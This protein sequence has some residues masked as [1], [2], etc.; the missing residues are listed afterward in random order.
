MK[1]ENTFHKNFK[2]QGKSFEN[3]FDLIDFSRSIST[4]I[5]SFLKE[6]FNSKGYIEV[7]TSG[8]T[9]KSKVVQLQKKQAIHSAIATGEYFKLKD[10]T[11]AL[12][13]MSPDYIAGKK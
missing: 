2:L 12:L 8:S 5:N 11:K 3:Y 13:C 1:I 9:G 7:K 6:W 10:T 4:D